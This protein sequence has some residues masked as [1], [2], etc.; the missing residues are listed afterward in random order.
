MMNVGHDGGIS[1]RSRIRG[2]PGATA[3]PRN[4][5]RGFPHPSEKALA[6][7]ILTLELH[8]PRVLDSPAPVREGWGRGKRGLVV[9]V[10]WPVGSLAVFPASSRQ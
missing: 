10:G 6:G 7:V 9:S 1:V 4:Y 2:A 8:D 5:C 3:H